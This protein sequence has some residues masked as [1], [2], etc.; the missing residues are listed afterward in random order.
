MP[1]DEKLPSFLIISFSSIVDTAGLINDGFER[2]VFSQSSISYSTGPS[3]LCVLLVIAMITTSDES[4]LYLSELMI[5]AGRF[6]D[7]LWSL[8]GKGTSTTSPLS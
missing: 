1:F 8:N 5:T 3:A 4:L 6:F 2:P 7:A